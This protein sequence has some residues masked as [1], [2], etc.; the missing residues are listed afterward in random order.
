MSVRLALTTA[1]TRSLNVVTTSATLIDRSVTMLD[2]LAQSGELHADQYLETT[3]EEIETNGSARRLKRITEA[4]ISLAEHQRDI[5][6]RLEA[7]PEL[8]AIYDSISFDNQQAAIAA[9]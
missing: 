1:T 2:K 3:R 9:E 5:N 6:K 8:K 4:R 7:D